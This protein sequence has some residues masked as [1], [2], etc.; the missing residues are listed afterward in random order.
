MSAKVKPVAEWKD[1]CTTPETPKYSDCSFWVAIKATRRGHDGEVRSIDTHV[2][3][4]Q[5]VNRPL[6]RDDD[7]DFFCDDYLVTEDGD[8]LDAVGWFSVKSHHDFDN[9]FEPLPFGDDY[10]L[11]G[12]ADFDKPE[13]KDA[14]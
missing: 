12:W 8:P 3:E 9:Y 7:G 6:E 5:Y 11:L 2:F 1:P 13:Y 4:A 10:V 14:N